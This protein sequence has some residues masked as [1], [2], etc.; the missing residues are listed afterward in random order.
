MSTLPPIGYW[1][2]VLSARCAMSIIVFSNTIRCGELINHN[3]WVLLSLF[4][5]TACFSPDFS[6]HKTFE[7][8]RSVDR[9]RGSDVAVAEGA[10]TFAKLVTKRT[11]FVTHGAAS[12]FRF[13][14]LPMGWAVCMKKS[15]VCFEK[16]RTTESANYE[17]QKWWLQ[18]SRLG[19]TKRY[20]NAF[21]SNSQ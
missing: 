19:L 15:L 1:K 7:F 9:V 5:W 16:V 18:A 3:A 14:W 13:L 8:S 12:L 11:S 21:P 20:M 2:L 17:R 4:V 6:T 10:P